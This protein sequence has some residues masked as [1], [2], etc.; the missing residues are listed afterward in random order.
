MVHIAKKKNISKCCQAH[1]Y[2]IFI[3]IIRTTNPIMIVS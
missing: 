3:S 1:D 2:D